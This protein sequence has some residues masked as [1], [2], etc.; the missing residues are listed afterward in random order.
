MPSRAAIPTPEPVVAEPRRVEE[1]KREGGGRGVL[2]GLV[3]GIVVVAIAIGFVLAP[4][5]KQQGQPEGL[6]NS[7][8]AGPLELAFPASWHKAPAPAIPGLALTDPIGLAGPAR[9]LTVAAGKADGVAPTLLPTAFLA[10]LGSAPPAPEAVKLG[11]AP[12]YRYANLS[13][14][15]PD[16][17]L[18]VYAVPTDA[19][20]VAIACVGIATIAS[21]D[22]EAIATSLK[23]DGA[24]ALGLGPDPAYAKALGAALNTLNGAAAQQSETLVRA[25]SRAAQSKA[26]NDLA[27]TYTNAAK[28]INKLPVRPSEQTANAAIA[29]AATAIA[30]DYKALGQA[31]KS[32]DSKRYRR[33]TTAVAADDAKL[34]KALTALKALGY[35]PA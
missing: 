29:A 25:K 31:A 18:T 9:G 14:Q 27:K 30:R 10:R 13:A 15:N 12:A 19:G 17:K 1:P 24:K 2:V 11:D 7:T 3:V 26:A 23:L 35:A 5:K 32:G 22:C 6:P 8:S 20:T 34:T 21:P 16:Q 28:A 33:A 4:S